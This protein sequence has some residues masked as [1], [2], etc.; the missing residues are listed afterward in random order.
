MNAK[1]VA[2]AAAVLAAVVWYEPVLKNIYTIQ[3]CTYTF[4]LI[5]KIKRE[6][7][8]FILLNLGEF[9]RILDSIFCLFYRN[10]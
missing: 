10:F 8:N 2:E 1:E 6:N 7:I 4:R 5:Y 9:P 3:A